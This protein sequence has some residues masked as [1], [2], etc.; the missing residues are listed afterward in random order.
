MSDK[1]AGFFFH[2]SWIVLVITHLG[3]T[4]FVYHDAIK[5]DKRALNIGAKWWGFFTLFGGFW[6]LL[7][8]WAMQH[9]ALALSRE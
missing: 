7:A 3:C 1:F 8:Y 4:Y 2:V 9:S 6:T 5:L